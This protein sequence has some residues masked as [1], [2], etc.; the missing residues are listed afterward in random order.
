MTS[1]AVANFPGIFVQN[2]SPSTQNPADPDSPNNH[3]E[4]SVID[5]GP[6][7]STDPESQLGP[8][9]TSVLLRLMAFLA[10]ALPLVLLGV[11]T[12][13]SPSASG[14]GTHQQLGLPPCS[15]RV[16]FGIPC[17]ACGMTTSWAHF[18]RG[19]FLKSAQSNIGGLALAF[20]CL[21]FALVSA[22]TAFLGDWPSIRVQKWLAFSLMAIAIVTVVSWIFR[23]GIL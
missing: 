18:V 23:L 8:R 22:K 21:A 16:F 1:T 11:T 4:M 13:L 2:H 5:N 20:Y 3:R 19:Q 14:L 12:Q 15:T 6:T 10:A 9:K 7:D 17:P